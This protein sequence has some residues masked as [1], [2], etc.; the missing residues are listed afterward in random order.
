M[1][2]A[3]ALPQALASQTAFPQT[4]SI[5]GESAQF[6][7]TGVTVLIAETLIEC[8]SLAYALQATAASTCNHDPE[9]T[10]EAEIENGVVCNSICLAGDCRSSE[11]GS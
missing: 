5:A 7:L 1:A 9:L 10:I 11:A 4:S 8:A 6:G 3:A 2:Y